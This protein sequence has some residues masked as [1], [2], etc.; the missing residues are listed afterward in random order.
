MAVKFTN[1]VLEEVII[2]SREAKKWKKI[3]AERR[4]AGLS[5]EDCRLPMDCALEIKT[6][7]TLEEALTLDRIGA[8]DIINRGSKRL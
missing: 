7:L 2:P 1:R 3:R 8:L 4:A 6:V 5:D